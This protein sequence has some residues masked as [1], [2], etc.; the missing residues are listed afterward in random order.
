[1]SRSYHQG[2]DSYPLFTGEGVNQPSGND[3]VSEITEIKNRGHA[4]TIDNGCR[5]V[6][7]RL[8]QTVRITVPR[9]WE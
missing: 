7:P 1:M 9:V 6:P 5:E 2:R 4:L 8:R 3:S